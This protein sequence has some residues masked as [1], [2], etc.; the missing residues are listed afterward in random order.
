VKFI[1]SAFV[2]TILQEKRKKERTL[3]QILQPTKALFS[4]RVGNAKLKTNEVSSV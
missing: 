2:N 4:F 1:A 3:Q